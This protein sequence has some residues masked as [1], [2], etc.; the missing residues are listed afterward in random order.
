MS[1]E[2]EKVDLPV[3]R[4]DDRDLPI[5]VPGSGPRHEP[6]SADACP[7]WF[8]LASQRHIRGLALDPAKSEVWLATGGGV[9]RWVPDLHCFTRYGSE[10]GLPGNSVVAVAVDG[11][12]LVWVAHESSGVSY[13]DGNI[14]RPYT[15]LNEITANC[16]NKDSLGRLWVGSASG[17]YAIGSPSRAPMIELPPFG[18]PPR[19]IAVASEDD[20]WLCSARG[21]FHFE[22]GDWARYH[23]RPDVLT[24]LRWKEDLWLGTLSGLVQI[25]LNTG[26]EYH[27]DTWPMSEVTAL[28]PTA[29]GV[30]AAIG[31]E[32]GRATDGSWI[33]ISRQRL[34]VRITGLA[35]RGDEEVWIGTHHGLLRADPTG[36]CFQLTDTPPDVIGLADSRRPSVPLSNMIQ[37]LV[38]QQGATGTVL[39]IGTANGLFCLDILTESWKQFSS[40]RDVRAF[41]AGVTTE[42]IWVAGWSGG[43]HLLKGR[44]IQKAVSDVPG[45]LTA[46]AESTGPFRWVAGLDGLY[47]G[48]GLTW[49]CV[50]PAS[51][52]PEKSWIWTVMQTHP[53]RVWLGTSIG[54]FV[55]NPDT[56]ALTVASGIP[57]NPGIR[58]LLSISK[59]GSEYLWVGTNDGLYAGPPD[60]LKP[61][62][63]F[64]GQKV[65]A[66]AWDHTSTILWVGT[67]GS[68]LFCLAEQG[69]GWKIVRAFTARNSGLAA[70]RVTTLVLSSGDSGERNLWIG[71]PCGLSCYTY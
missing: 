37:A 14:W 68:G 24:L 34:K 4:M 6:A 62:P 17:V 35:E 69:K 40:I 64:D 21:V 61:V 50:L 2:D 41:V 26:E 60:A 12:G 65:T 29:E 46:L 48:D 22:S 67:S 58:L 18:E 42:V 19:A 32:V 63:S 9:L 66:L 33:P 45:P 51:K 13:L 56:D 52:L 59:G 54:L 31:G 39:W 1:T 53:G 11:N 28:A 5:L 23:G 71:T 36:I 20:V 27:S 49:T 70:D 30:W 57:G 16:L 8:S 25:K 3:L 44:A 7:G 43:L 15:A 55:Y 10:H 47:R 38:V